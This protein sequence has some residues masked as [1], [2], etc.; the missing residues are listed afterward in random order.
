MKRIRIVLAALSLFAVSPLAQKVMACPSCFGATDSPV[1]DGM[2][3]AILTMLGITG[4][5]LT[6]IAAFFVVMIRNVRR[7]KTVCN[8]FVDEQGKI[9][10]NNS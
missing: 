6:G 9:T 5:V 4:M 3:T 7:S 10:W 8:P 2:N 1:V